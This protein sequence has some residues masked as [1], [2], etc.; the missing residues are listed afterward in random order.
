MPTPLRH[1]RLSFA[2]LM[3]AA[4]MA[5]CAT[6][7]APVPAES[8]IETDWFQAGRDDGLRGAPAKPLAEKVAACATAGVT[9]DTAEYLPG[10]NEGIAQFCTATNGWKQGAMGNEHRAKACAGQPDEAA[11]ADNLRN[12]LEVF[13]VNEQRRAN[14]VQLQQLNQK[15]NTMRDPTE[16]R[17]LQAQMT[18]LDKQQLVLRQQLRTLQQR[19]PQ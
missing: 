5:A 3:A 17:K 19:A 10:W 16:R 7:P 11:F 6:G 18:E 1:V 12:G 8:C 14:A 15:H 9:L 2:A 13:K 4:L